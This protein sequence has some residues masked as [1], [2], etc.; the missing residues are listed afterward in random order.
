MLI[1]VSFRNNLKL[2]D[3]A[4]V[5][6]NKYPLNKENYR[7]VSVLPSISKIFEKLIVYIGVSIPPS[8]LPILRSKL[9][10]KKTG[11]G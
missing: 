11:T 9:L 8:F 5:F 1:T 6:K 4:T 7:P 10:D 3:I 2:L